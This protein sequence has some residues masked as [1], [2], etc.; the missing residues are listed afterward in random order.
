MRKLLE[1]QRCVG[2]K[3]LLNDAGKWRGEG[4]GGEKGSIDSLAICP[5]QTW[6]GVYEYLKLWS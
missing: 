1:G 5:G 4:G 3:D 2:W 6:V